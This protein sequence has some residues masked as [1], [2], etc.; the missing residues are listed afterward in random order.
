MIVIYC[1]SDVV[2]DECYFIWIAN[3]LVLHV[4]CILIPEFFVVEAGRS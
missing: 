4:V 2:E 3:H 1:V